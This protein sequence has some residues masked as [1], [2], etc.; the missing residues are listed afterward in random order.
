MPDD[1][2]DALETKYPGFIARRL[3]VNTSKINA[4]LPKRY[5][6]PFAAPVPEIVIGWL[7]AMTAP[8]VYRKRGWDPGDAQ[9]AQIEQDRTDALA[10]IQAAVDSENGLYELPLREDTSTGGVVVGGAFGY[11]EPSPY[12]WLDLQAEAVRGR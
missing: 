1:D 8:E 11:A 10:E 7:V 12:D 6:T 2:V 9:S 3:V 5:A 4:Q